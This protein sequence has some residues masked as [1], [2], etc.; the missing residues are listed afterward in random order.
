[1]ELLVSGFA[2]GGLDVFVE[3][4]FGLGQIR[5]R[6]ARRSDGGQER[7]GDDDVGA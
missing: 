4:G 5:R 2:A 1:M 6:K 7:G 3:D